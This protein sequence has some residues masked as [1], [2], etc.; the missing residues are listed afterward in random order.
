MEFPPR[1]PLLST[2]ARRRA[3]NTRPPREILLVL[4]ALVDRQKRIEA[5]RA[6]FA[7]SSVA[8]ACKRVTLRK[9]SKNSSR[10]CP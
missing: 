7:S 10:E 8:T 4:D 6:R 3:A 2:T 5:P 9:S 1:A